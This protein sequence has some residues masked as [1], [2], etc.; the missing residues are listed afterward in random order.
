MGRIVCCRHCVAPKRHIGCH[1]TCPE[2]IVERAKNE[3]EYEA[4]IKRH[5]QDSDFYT[6]RARSKRKGGT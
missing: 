6:V 1:A 2:Y 4:R 5:D 3:K